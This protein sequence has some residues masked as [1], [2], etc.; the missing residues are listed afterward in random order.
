MLAFKVPFTISEVIDFDELRSK[1]WIDTEFD[2]I[3]LDAG[4]TGQYEQIEFEISNG[5]LSSAVSGKLSLSIQEV[6]QGTLLTSNFSLHF[7]DGTTIN[8]ANMLNPPEDDDFLEEKGFETEA[9]RDTWGSLTEN[10]RKSLEGLEASLLAA[11]IELIKELLWSPEFAYEHEFALEPLPKL[12]YEATAL[13]LK[14]AHRNNLN[15][16]GD[17]FSVAQ[18]YRSWWFTLEVRAETAW[19]LSSIRKQLAAEFNFET[20][21]CDSWL[22]FL[23]QCCDLHLA[24]QQHD[25]SN[26]TIKANPEIKTTSQEEDQLT[27]LFLKVLFEDDGEILRE[28]SADINQI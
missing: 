7:I 5:P 19:S 1:L 3:P 8:V 17:L 27:R 10:V 16:T 20:E 11:G 26:L 24:I 12:E 22:Y 28:I 18:P 25:L 23:S 21:A 2:L 4:L 14:W 15:C 6:V 9:I 13:I